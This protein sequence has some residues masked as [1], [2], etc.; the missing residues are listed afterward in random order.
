MA[1][2]ESMMEPVFVNVLCQ[3]AFSIKPQVFTVN[4]GEGIY[5][6]AYFHLHAV[7]LCF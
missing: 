7:V 6:G 3:F 5:D 1:L 2:M 4:G